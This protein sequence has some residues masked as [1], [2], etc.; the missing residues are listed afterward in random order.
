MKA[1]TMSLAVV[2][3]SSCLLYADDPPP[4]RLYVKTV[5]AGARIF[6]D[7]KDI[8]R[9]DDLFVIGP[10]THTIRVVLD[11]YATQEKQVQVP[12]ER[13][14][15]LEL[16]FSKAP[17]AATATGPAQESGDA[18]VAAVTYVKA[19]DLPAPV[20]DAMLTVLRQHPEETRWSGQSGQ[21]LFG[22]AAKVLPT[23]AA[24]QQAVP[25]LLNLT[26]LLAVQELL[27]AKSLLDRYAETGLTDSTTLGQAVVEAAGRLH[28]VGSVKTLK[29]QAAVRDGVAVAYVF[30]D[31]QD[32]TA[33][34]L[35]P[36]ELDTV[37][38]AYR[39]VMHGQA[40]S[41]MKQDNYKDA[42]LLWK[43]LHSRKLVSQSLYL[44]AARCFQAL[45]QHDDAVRV[46]SEAMDAFS[47]AAP[48]E[49][50]ERTGDV[51]LSI[52]SPAAQQLAEKAYNLA[53]ARLLSTISAASHPAN[54]GLEI[55][56]DQQPVP[57]SR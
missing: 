12:S 22:V 3:I 29:H 40:R 37:K 52:D 8:G 27:K 39:D 7:G 55:R 4:T 47:E 14:T 23:G 33:Q 31:E 57:P 9:S 42:I 2:V 15:R 56:V 20:R 18:S 32:L 48:A 53:S 34:L 44:D 6:L 41:L 11:G 50:F 43:H 24:R 17:A 16:E 1:A 51:A 5:P 28:V 21:T 26:H 36:V 25:A 46:L 54:V 45:K 19:T 30:A 35:Q 49:F 13:I 10:G 38:A